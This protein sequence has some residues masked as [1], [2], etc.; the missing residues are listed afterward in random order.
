[1]PRTPASNTFHPI[2]YDTL[3]G[4]SAGDL[5]HSLK[6]KEFPNSKQQDLLD[7]ERYL[8]AK[9]R[10]EDWVD[11]CIRVLKSRLKRDKKDA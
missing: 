1:M 4:S 8:E 5:S 2:Y 6:H 11:P 10:G 7:L 9:A 3:S